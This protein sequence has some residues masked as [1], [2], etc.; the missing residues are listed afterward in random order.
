MHQQAFKANI[1]FLR[2][3]A[4]LQPLLTRELA[5]VDEAMMPCHYDA[6]DIIIKQGD[7]PDKFY[8]IKRGVCT[9]SKKNPD[10][11]VERGD[12]PTG[13][14]FWGI[15]PPERPTASGNRCCQNRSRL[16]RAH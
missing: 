14:F 5:L 9:W 8:I 4:I 13:G 2:G 11:T 7:D 3:V 1:E 15:V 6:G 10:G 12:I 16:P